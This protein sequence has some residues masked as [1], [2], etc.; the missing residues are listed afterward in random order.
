MTVSLSKLHPT[1]CNAE[2]A[3][4]FYFTTVRAFR[5][6]IASFRY[7]EIQQPKSLK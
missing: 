5:R 2:Y 3:V 1:L 6:T 4:I 7:L